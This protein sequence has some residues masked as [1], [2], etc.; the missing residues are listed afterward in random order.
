MLLTLDLNSEVPIYQQLRDRVVEAIAVGELATGSA[1]PSTREL[2]ADLGIN[3]HTVNKA[4]DLLRQEGLL[5]LNRKSGAVI[6]RDPASG[7]PPTVFTEQWRARLRT[8]LAEAAAQGL[9]GP[10]VLADC[11][12]TLDGFGLPSALPAPELGDPA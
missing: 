10:A 9:D 6:Q 12:A 3:F 7:P 4:Y 8:L 5:I 1:L 2:A 11:A